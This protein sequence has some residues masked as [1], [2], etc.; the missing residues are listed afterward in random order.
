[1]PHKSIS[2]IS[3]VVEGEMNTINALTG[4]LGRFD[5][6]EVKTIITKNRL[7][8]LGIKR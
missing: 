7:T 4:K 5:G 2:F 8:D 6:I 3:L 1:M